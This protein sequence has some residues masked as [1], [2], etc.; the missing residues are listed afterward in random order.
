M[1]LLLAARE[2]GRIIGALGVS[3]P[4]WVMTHRAL[5]DESQRGLLAR[6]I[7]HV[8]GVAVHPDHRRRGIGRALLEEAR[9]RVSHEGYLLMTL[10]HAEDLADFYQ[11]LG[12]TTV[13]E[14]AIYTPRPLLTQPPSPGL[15]IAVRT[16]MGRVGP[17]DVPGLAGPVVDGLVNLE[18]IPAGAVFYPG[19]GLWV[20]R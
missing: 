7:A 13:G 14:L 5:R 1:T 8:H 2:N 16:L 10:E 3:V 19:R 15:A 18:R 6:V 9:K 12:F 11:R 20:P 17:R 4:E